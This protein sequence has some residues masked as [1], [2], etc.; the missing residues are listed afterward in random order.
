MRFVY[1]STSK[2]YATKYDMV[3]QRLSARN[4]RQQEGIVK[5]PEAR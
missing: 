4:G 1:A 2:A 3:S 5:L